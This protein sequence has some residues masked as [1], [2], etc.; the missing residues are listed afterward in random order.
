VSGKAFDDFR[1]G[2]EINRFI[3]AAVKFVRE[4]RWVRIG[5]IA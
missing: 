3:Q 4:R 1:F 5:E 2:P